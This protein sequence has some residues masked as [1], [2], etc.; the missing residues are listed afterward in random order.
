[1]SCHSGRERHTRCRS[2]VQH[3]GK[4]GTWLGVKVIGGTEQWSWDASQCRER[5][6]SGQSPAEEGVAGGRGLG[7]QTA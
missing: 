4:E 5:L 2:A 1:M 3:V 6:V 7:R